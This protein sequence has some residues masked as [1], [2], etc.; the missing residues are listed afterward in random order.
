M[1]TTNLTIKNTYGLLLSICIISILSAC[2]SEEDTPSYLD[3][4]H[5]KVTDFEKHKFEHEFADQCVK[6]ELK[7]SNN[8]D[9]IRKRVERECLC[10]ASSMMEDLTAKEAEKFLKEHKD[11][12]SL[13]IKF[14]NAAYFCTK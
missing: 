8:P 14:N 3:H 1:K 4:P 10:I 9:N 13:Q 7:R 2:S 11:T 5:T 6:R 12:R